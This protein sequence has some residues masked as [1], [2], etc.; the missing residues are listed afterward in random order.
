MNITNRE[1]KYPVSKLLDAIKANR[2]RHINDFEEA[3][4]E[5]RR[6]AT[7]CLFNAW[8]EAKDGGEIRRT[9]DLPEPKSHKDDYDQIIAMLEMTSDEIIRLDSRE[10]A[11]F[12]MD[13]WEWKKQFVHVN[14]S[15]N[16]GNQ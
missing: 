7:E 8:Q 15:Y 12:V 4:G 2:E 10:F 6:R 11:M 16:I 13:D 3:L 5:Y 1:Y 9:V 14:R